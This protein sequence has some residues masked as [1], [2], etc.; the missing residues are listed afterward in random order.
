M[1]SGLIRVSIGVL[2]IC[3]LGAATA[4]LLRRAPSAAA[5]ELEASEGPA[6]PLGEEPAARAEWFQRQR[7]YPA[8]EIPPR[9]TRRAARQADRLELHEARLATAAPLARL[10]LD[11]PEVDQLRGRNDLVVGGPRHRGRAGRRRNGRVRR[12]RSGRRLEDDRRRRDTGHRSS[13]TRSAPEEPGSRSARLRSIR[14]IRT[15][16]TSEPVKRTSCSTTTSATGSSSPRT[17][18][19]RGRRSAVRSS[20]RVTSPIIEIR[21]GTILASAVRVG[22]WTRSCVGGVYRS[23]DGGATWARTLTDDSDTDSPPIKPDG[24]PPIKTT[25]AFDVAPGV[26][27]TWFATVH[28]DDPAH[29][30]GNIFRSTNDGASWTRLGGRPADDGE[31][32][33]RARDRADRPEPDL[34][35]HLEHR[36]RQLRQPPRHLH[37]GR[38][39]NDVDAAS[40]AGSWDESLLVRN[41]RPRHMQQATHDRRRPLDAGTVYARRDLAVQVD[42][43]RTNVDSITA[44]HS[45]YNAFA[46]DTTGRMWIGNDG[47]VSRRAIDELAREPER[48]PSHYPVRVGHRG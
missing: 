20:T 11:R 40:A 21:S 26:A 2:F 17:Q 44:G 19:A 37:V 48:E 46:F 24:L 1:G 30:G 18:A 47:G 45:D 10:D 29:A 43:L 4:F 32:P 9:G 23:T 39:R 34:C 22:R 3:A 8:G 12:R 6:G 42:G 27:G 35:R 16:C 33:N 36:Q 13:T 7:A 31:R 28:G 25:G 14:P 15:R 41:Q 5:L 38:R